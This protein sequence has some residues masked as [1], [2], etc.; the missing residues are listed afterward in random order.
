MQC[1]MLPI[2]HEAHEYIV[3]LHSECLF[4]FL[5]RCMSVLKIFTSVSTIAPTQMA[6]IFVPA[7][8]DTSLLPMDSAALVGVLNFVIIRG[9]PA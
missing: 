4:F 8:L 1:G 2:C 6:P 7:I 5:Q 3:C 9:E